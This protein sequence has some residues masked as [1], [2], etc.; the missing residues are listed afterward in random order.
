MATD[1]FPVGA[2]QPKKETGAT[3]FLA[4]NPQADGRNVVI[5]I[6]DSGNR[7]GYMS[8]DL[9]TCGISVIRSKTM[10]APQYF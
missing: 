10:W 9:H 1:L 5:A 2:L 3:A 7:V 8:T 4:K 6:F